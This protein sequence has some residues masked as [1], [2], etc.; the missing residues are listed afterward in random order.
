M[1]QLI[2]PSLARLPGRL[3]HVV[4]FAICPGRPTALATA[5]ASGNLVRCLARQGWTYT[6]AAFSLAISNGLR[7]FE[8][9]PGITIGTPFFG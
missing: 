7:P 3:A 6:L 5:C 9:S 2:P 8:P 1:G 4:V